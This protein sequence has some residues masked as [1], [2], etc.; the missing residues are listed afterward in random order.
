MYEYIASHVAYNSYQSS[1]FWFQHF[2]LAKCKGIVANAI[3]LLLT[4][5]LYLLFELAIIL[6]GM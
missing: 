4:R 3:S 2:I 5:A 6:K 1:H